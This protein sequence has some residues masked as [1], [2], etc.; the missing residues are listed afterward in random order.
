MCEF[1]TRKNLIFCK[2][3][4]GIL[5]LSGLR[6]IYLFYTIYIITLHK[7]WKFF[8]K[9][10]FSKCDQIRIWLHLLKKSLMKNFIFL[11]R[12]KA[13]YF[14]NKYCRSL[15]YCPVSLHVILQIY[16]IKVTIYLRLPNYDKALV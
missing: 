9:D 16:L 12:V 13:K 4:P 8:I 2:Q 1:R 3:F 15:I 10:L 6:K 14:G 11:C 7:K 5:C